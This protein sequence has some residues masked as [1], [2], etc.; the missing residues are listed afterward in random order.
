[1]NKRQYL[2]QMINDINASLNSRPVSAK[3]R[4]NKKRAL[5]FYETELAKEL[6][7]QEIDKKD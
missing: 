1:M 3:I 4:A 7:I 6:G 5:R 2:E